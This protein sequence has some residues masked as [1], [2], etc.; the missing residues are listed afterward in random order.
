MVLNELIKVGK[1]RAIETS[2]VVLIESSLLS[3]VK[4]YCLSKK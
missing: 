1:I 2:S 3:L 4:S